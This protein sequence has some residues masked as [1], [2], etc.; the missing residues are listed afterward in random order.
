MADR[1]LS[2]SHTETCILLNCVPKSVINLKQYQLLL[3]KNKPMVRHSFILLQNPSIIP[4]HLLAYW[5]LGV[6]GQLFKCDR[7]SLVSGCC[8]CSFFLWPSCPQRA[9]DEPEPQYSLA[10]K[11]FFLLSFNLYSGKEQTNHLYAMIS[12]IISWICGI[13]SFVFRFN[14]YF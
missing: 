1:C 2:L 13:Y 3:M 5:W 10:E 8:C 9:R 6:G 11:P 7:W 12:F 14:S 4:E